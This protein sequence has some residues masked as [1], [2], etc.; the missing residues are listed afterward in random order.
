MTKTPQRPL[1]LLL[2]LRERESC[3]GLKTDSD[4]GI[5]LLQ[6]FFRA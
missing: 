1:P 3:R 6:F 4:M 2:S 5:A